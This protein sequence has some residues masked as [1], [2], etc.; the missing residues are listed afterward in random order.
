MVITDIMMPFSSGLEIISLVRQKIKKK[1]PIIILS[2]I[3]Q[4]KWC[5]RLLSWGPTIISQNLLA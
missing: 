2:A 5:W 1:I 4:E 3:E